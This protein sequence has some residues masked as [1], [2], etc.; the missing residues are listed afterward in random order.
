MN[1]VAQQ[2]SPAA[3]ADPFALEQTVE[4]SAATP[5]KPREPHTLA[6]VNA[7]QELDPFGEPSLLE[8]H[9]VPLAEA[10]AVASVRAHHWSSLGSEIAFVIGLA[11]GLSTGLLVW[12][13]SRLR[14]VQVPNV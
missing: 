5:S 1:A 14:K 13:R 12:L 4:T 2:V 11:V 10:T 8:S 7:A 6:S 9:D 3:V